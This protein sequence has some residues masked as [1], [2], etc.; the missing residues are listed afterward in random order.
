MPSGLVANEV[1][2]ESPT[3]DDDTDNNLAAAFIAVNGGAQ[4]CTIPVAGAGPYAFDVCGICGSVAFTETGT[5][6]TLS[7]TFT[8]QYPAINGQGLPRQYKIT[9]LNGAGSP[10]TGYNAALTLCYED[11]ELPIAGIDPADEPYLMAF[12]HTGGGIWSAPIPQSIAAG[13]NLVT[14]QDVT[15]FSAW[16]IGIV[17]QEEPA[18]VQQRGLDIRGNIRVT[19]LGVALLLLLSVARMR[20]QRRRR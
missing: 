1:E 14:V 15:A 3:P 17:D 20:Q 12:R 8:R 4:E 6:N 9:A 10:G 11:E 13:A 16:G 7:I 18:V 19:A 5:V 2:I